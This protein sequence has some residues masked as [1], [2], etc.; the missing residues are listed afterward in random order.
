MSPDRITQRQRRARVTEQAC[1]E[2]IREEEARQGRPLTPREREGFARG[3][4]SEEYRAEVRRLMA[5]SVT[6][7]DDS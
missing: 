4:F 5:L 1:Q 7:E 6:D 2:A 3:F